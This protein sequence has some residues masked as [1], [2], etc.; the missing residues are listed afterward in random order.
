MSNST[1]ESSNQGGEE[2]SS[3]LSPDMKE[4]R[5]RRVEQLKAKMEGLKRGIS[6]GETEGAFPDTS[7]PR[8]GGSEIISVKRPEEEETPS[9]EP[10]TKAQ[11]NQ[12]GNSN[13]HVEAKPS[14]ESTRPALQ[15]STSSPMTRIVSMPPG[16]I[17]SPSLAKRTTTAD[18]PSLYNKPATPKK[19]R[20]NSFSLEPTQD[21]LSRLIEIQALLTNVR[22]P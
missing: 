2:L 19:E 15:K 4:D 18:P 5:K 1:N 7:E 9:S 22:H 14:I 3:P 16:K 8:I 12:N 17:N 20:N 21:L 13:G 6:L 10:P 11:N